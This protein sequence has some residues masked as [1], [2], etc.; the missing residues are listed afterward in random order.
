V[1]S[2]EGTPPVYTAGL[3]EKVRTHTLAWSTWEGYADA[4]YKIYNNDIGYITHRQFIMF[5]D[6]LQGAVLR[7]LTDTSGTFNDLEEMLKKPEIQKLTE[8]LRRSF[9]IV[10]AG[11]TPRDIEYQEKVLDQI[12]AETSGWK[13]AAMEEPTMAGWSALYMIKLCYKALNYAYSGG[14]FDAMARA[15]SPDL[16]KDPWMATMKE[17]KRKFGKQGGIVDD[18]GDAGMGSIGTT[19]GGGYHGFENFILYDP[20]DAASVAAAHACNIDAG[21]VAAGAGLGGFNFFFIEWE[22]LQKLLAERS[23]STIFNWQR[24]IREALDPNGLGDGSYLYLE[25]PE[26]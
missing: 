20:G 4:V 12:L 11:M 23:S 17:Q 3:M 26:K 8:E 16:A 22:R 7:I 2:I 13:V 19:G 1:M 10:L 24:K 14:F 18:G 5:G 21:N 25:K 6:E 9:Q 15:G